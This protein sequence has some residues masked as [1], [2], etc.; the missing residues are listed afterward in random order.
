MQ[1]C[2]SL[3]ILWHCYNWL[4]NWL[5]PNTNKKILKKQLFAEPLYTPLQS[6]E[7]SCEPLCGKTRSPV[8]MKF[9]VPSLHLWLSVSSHN[10]FIATLLSWFFKLHL[11]IYNWRIIALQCCV[12][13][14]CQTSA[15][16]GHIYTYVPSLLNPLPPPSPSH[17]S[18]L[19]SP[20]LGFLSH[21]ANSHH[22]FTSFKSPFTNR[23]MSVLDFSD[24]YYWRLVV[25]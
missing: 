6:L 8:S 5:Y 19:Q 13:G 21:T 23:S 4:Y 9:Q 25:V 17:P 7:G 24:A 20:S 16:I 14:F 22:P 3:H 18:W 15:G 11:F 10:L 12:F 1:L 2:G